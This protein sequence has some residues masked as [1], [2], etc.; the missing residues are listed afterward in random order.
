MKS[1]MVKR[2]REKEIPWFG[3]LIG[4]GATRRI[5]E[6]SIADPRAFHTRPFIIYVLI[7]YN[8]SSAPFDPSLPPF[9]HLESAKLATE[10]RHSEGR[11][12]PIHPPMA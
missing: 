8:R 5:F 2:E 11:V 6:D 1:R 10:Q 9:P 12:V 4:V 3:T 7:Y